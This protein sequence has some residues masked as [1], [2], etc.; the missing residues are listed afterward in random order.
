MAIDSIPSAPVGNVADVLAAGATKPAIPAAKDQFGEDTFLKLL[1]AQLRYQD[2]SNPSNGSEFLAQT[3]QFTSLEKLT[4]VAKLSTEL[5][6]AQRLLGASGLVGRSVTYTQEDG[7]DVTGV[8]TSARFETDGV[9]LLVNDA[10]VPMAQ[11][12]EVRSTA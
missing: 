7:S 6:A 3:A 12:K 5:V 9:V 4:Q 8:V 10:K 2:P 11:V 1:V